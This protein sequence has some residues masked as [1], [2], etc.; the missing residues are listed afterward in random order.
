MS[1]SGRS[2]EQQV[3]GL[4]DSDD[5]AVYRILTFGIRHGPGIRVCCAVKED[6]DSPGRGP[7]CLGAT[8]GTTAASGLE[9]LEIGEYIRNLVRIQPELGH[10]RMLRDDPLSQG[11]TQ[12]FDRK[13]KVQGAKRRRDRE[14]ALADLIYGMALRAICSDKC[15]TTLLGWGQLRQ[16]G[17]SEA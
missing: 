17:L 13:S 15:Q 14:R 2:R 4:R 16:R 3:I 5:R 10:A 11:P 9:R 6:G 8:N 12:V 1:D 7:P